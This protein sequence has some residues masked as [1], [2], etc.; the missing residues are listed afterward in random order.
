M[1]K[2]LVKTFCVLN[3]ALNLLALI[4]E[5][6]KMNGFLFKYLIANVVMKIYTIDICGFS[7]FGVIK[8]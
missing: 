8:S 3:N 6:K 2:L 7:Y 4:R 5:K 1:R